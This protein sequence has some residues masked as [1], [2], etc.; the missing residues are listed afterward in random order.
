MTGPSIAPARSAAFRILT[1]VASSN[2]HSDDLL[3]GAEV[4]RLSPPDRALTTTLVL[5]VLRWQPRLDAQIRSFLARPDADVPLAVEMALL[6]GAYQLLHLDRIPAYAAIGESVELAKQAGEVHAS[7]MVNAVLRKVSALP[8]SQ[9]QPEA[10]NVTQLANLF[11]HPEWMV[12]R[13]KQFFG[14]AAAAAICRAD[15]EPSFLSI[16]LLHPE[17]EATLAEDGIETAPGEFLTSA[18]RIVSGDVLRSR[19]LRTGQIRIQEEASQ[20]VAELAGTGNNILDTCAAPG[21]KTAILAERNPQAHITAWEI[22]KARMAAMKR[23]LGEQE[24]MIFEVCDATQAHPEPVY[25]LILCDAP[26]SGTGTIGRNPEIRYR[27]DED[28][29][30]RQQSRQLK[31]LNAAAAGVAE[32]GSLLYSTCSLE[33]EENETVIDTFLKSNPAFE[34]ASLEEQAEKLASAGR[35]HTEGLSKLKQ[36]ALIKGKLRTIPGMQNCD[37]FFAAR[38]KRKG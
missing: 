8:R 27:L 16:R 19:A 36:S 37:G 5:G 21:G 10:K 35:I 29:I 23:L 3:G 11:A 28:D 13:W 26:C 6:L 12:S 33:P 9:S 4:N 2:A 22:S 30:L 15:Q 18:R 7:R 14:F 25:D 17:A 32:N 20:L 24:K 38:L 34:L 1:E 31:I